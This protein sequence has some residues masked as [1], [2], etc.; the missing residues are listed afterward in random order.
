MWSLIEDTG[1]PT[2]VVGFG[3]ADS[4]ASINVAVVESPFTL[5]ESIEG[6]KDYLSDYLSDFSLVYETQ[7]SIGGLDCYEFEYT[8]TQLG[9]RLKKFVTIEIL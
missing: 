2:V 1:I 3:K 6:I 8:M 4:T 5:S 9:L 7:R